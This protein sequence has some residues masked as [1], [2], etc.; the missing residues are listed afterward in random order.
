MRLAQYDKKQPDGYGR[1][2]D[3]QQ[4][5]KVHVETQSAAPANVF[6]SVNDESVLPLTR[7]YER[8]LLVLAALLPAMATGYIYFFQD[9][10]IRFA[11]HGF[12]EIAI[13][14]ALLQ[15][16]F[17][18][19]V[20]W[21]CYIA[22][23]EPLLRWVT[24]SFLGFTLVYA[25]HGLM[26]RLSDHHLWLFL[27]YGPLS[28]LVMAVCLFAGMLAYGKAAHSPARRSGS[29]SWMRWI[30]GF[31]VLDALA[32]WI[33]LDSPS[34]MPAIRLLTECVAL[35]LLLVGMGF[36][37]QRQI[38]SPLMML[39]AFSLAYLA[40]SSAVFLLAK[41]WDQLWWLA[42][43]ISACGFTLLSYGVVRAFHTTRAFS[44]VFSQEE[45]MQQLTVAKA[46]AEASAEQLRLAN[47]NL[48]ILATTD[49][50][51]GVNNRR[52]FMARSH[53]DATRILR[54]GTS[55]ALLAL[56]IDHFKQI[57]DTFGHAVGDEVLKEFAQQVVK[58]LR[59]S[60]TVGRLGGEEF[61][62]LLPD[63]EFAEAQNIAER[64]RE[65]IEKMRIT[66]PGVSISITV[67][68]GL[69]EFPADNETLEQAFR[70]AD[71]RLYRAKK[72][73]RNQV[74]KDS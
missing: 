49:P 70:I 14:I 11:G 57:N 5:S 7:L 39:Y 16:S 29:T 12:H 73:G 2:A 46:V 41:P 45:I 33:A 4:I 56:D 36:I 10:S 69:A 62:I 38:K 18:G 13:S 74:V 50:L 26:T 23:G 8:L 20:T 40:Q 32:A 35:A 60:D 3:H 1:I 71:E 52:A 15:S 61:M 48:E 21:R 59:P 66:K 22:S 30:A 34:S 55:V 63:T 53:A 72:L 65:A 68:I 6:L 31:L 51:T 24:L 43:F 25:P 37:A 47:A 64:I 44:L 67:S 19:Y 42:H 17:V 28:R 9:P 27:Y 58:Q 54:A